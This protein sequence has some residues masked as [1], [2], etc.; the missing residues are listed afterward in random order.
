MPKQQ[1][2]LS[3]VMASRRLPPKKSPS[4]NHSETPLERFER[5]MGGA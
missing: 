4:I 1:K 5:L 2:T 3:V